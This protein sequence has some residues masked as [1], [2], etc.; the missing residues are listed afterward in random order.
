MKGIPKYSLLVRAYN[1][2]EPASH[3]TFPKQL[4]GTRLIEGLVG[5]QDFQAILSVAEIPS[6]HEMMI[7]VTTCC[8]HPEEQNNHLTTTGPRLE[9]G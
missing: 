2:R 1:L 9:K 7:Q 5:A 4:G 8:Q 3:V 6:V